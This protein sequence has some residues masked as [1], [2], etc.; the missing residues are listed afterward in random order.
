[1]TI[2]QNLIQTIQTSHR[3]SILVPSFIVL[4]LINLN[5]SYTTFSFLVGEV[6][7]YE[8]DFFFYIKKTTFIYAAHNAKRF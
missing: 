4:V 2:T 6:N 1:M 5:K 3:G 7:K 8:N